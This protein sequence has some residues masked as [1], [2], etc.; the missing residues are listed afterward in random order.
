MGLV[1][2][3]PRILASGLTLVMLSGCVGPWQL[4]SGSIPL[5]SSPRDVYTAAEYGTVEALETKLEE[6]GSLE[7]RN[8]DG[9]TPLMLAAHSSVMVT[10]NV[11]LLL[12]RGADVNARDLRGWTPLMFSLTAIWALQHSQPRSL[13][14]VAERVRMLID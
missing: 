4:G 9:R 7:A 2:M 8:G 5:E 14:L 11:R 3:L 10:A 13:E 1:R 6:P 12:E